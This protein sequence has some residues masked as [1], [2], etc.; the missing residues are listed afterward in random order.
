MRESVFDRRR[1]RVFD[2]TMIL[3]RWEGEYVCVIKRWEWIWRKWLLRREWLWENTRRMRESVCDQNMSTQAYFIKRIQDLWHTN[4]RPVT[5]KYKTL[6]KLQN[7]K[8]PR[9]IPIQ[10]LWL[11]TTK[12]KTCDTKLQNS[13]QDYKYKTTKHKTC[14]TRSRLFAPWQKT[15]TTRR[16]DSIFTWKKNMKSI[17]T[18]KT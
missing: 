5:Y 1:I 6:R 2:Q 13:S 10:N 8:T 7:N 3:V 11:K 15:T 12:H 9:D 17:T 16:R 14:S 18:T 4:T